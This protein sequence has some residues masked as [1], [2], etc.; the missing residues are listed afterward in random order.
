MPR[1]TFVCPHHGE[2]EV[3]LPKRQPLGRFCLK[4]DQECKNI[5]KAKGGVS[6]M[7]RLDNG[8]MG[9]AVERL[10]NIEE[11]VKERAD[12]DLKEYLEKVELKD[13]NEL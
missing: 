9:R 1:Y 7:E 10:H 6:V 5:F 2:I 8:L 3:S 4:C 11:I 13:D 12:K